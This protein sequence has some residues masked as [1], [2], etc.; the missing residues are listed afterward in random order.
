MLLF[1][2]AIFGVASWTMQLGAGT[3]ESP[4]ADAVPG[5]AL[6]AAGLAAMIAA[7]AA[8]KIGGGA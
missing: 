1:L 5:F 3:T 6:L 8:R 4:A 7:I 2:N